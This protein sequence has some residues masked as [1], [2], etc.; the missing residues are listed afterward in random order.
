VEPIYVFDGTDDAPDW[1]P[2]RKITVRGGVTVYQAWNVGL[3]LVS[4]PFVMNLN[5]EDRLAPDA[6]AMLQNSLVRERAAL[7]GG[8]W[9]ICHSQ[10]ETDAVEPCYDAARLPIAP[11]WPPPS[12]ARTRLGSGT[13]SRGTLG[14]AVMWSL[15]AHVGAP[16]YPWRLPDGS[17]LRVAGDSAW[18]TL[19]TQHLGKK[20]VCLPMVIGNYH[21][22]CAAQ[23]VE[24]KDV[25]EAA[26]M[27]L[28]GLS[29]V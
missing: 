24:H 25:D 16:R 28:L 19:V 6:I 3:S 1:L 7:I 26:L 27:R 23:P 18:L 17:L 22:H 9:N 10:C 13:G 20:A 15:D 11:Q 21:S 14:P 4:T 12:G 8:D 5:L 29:L 2:G